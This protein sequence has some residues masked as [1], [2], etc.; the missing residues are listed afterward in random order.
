MTTPRKLAELYAAFDESTDIVPGSSNIATRDGRYYIGVDHGA[1]PGE[2]RMVVT[3]RNVD[4]SLTYCGDQW[5]GDLEDR[6]RCAVC[7]KPVDHL[8]KYR[9]EYR[10]ECVFEARCH[11]QREI[12]R[13]K[14]SE[15]VH[16]ETKPLFLMEAF[17]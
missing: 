9:D 4:G 16:D 17:R 11:G 6:P 13:M 10:N 14:Q 3:Q 12:V 5:I 7:K 1:S 2:A 15:I 8:V